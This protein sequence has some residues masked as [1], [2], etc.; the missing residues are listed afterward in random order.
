VNGPQLLL[1]ELERRRLDERLRL[2]ERLRLDEL[3]PEA[4]VLRRERDEPRLDVLRLLGERRLLLFF[5]VLEPLRA[6]CSFVRPS[7]LRRLF[8]VRAAISFER[9]LDL[10]RFLLDDLIFSY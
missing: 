2:V 4:G 5:L 7:V 8:T 6:D 3:R 9:L 10:P 1:R